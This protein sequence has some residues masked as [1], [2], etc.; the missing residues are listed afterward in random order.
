MQLIVLS[1]LEN[2]FT[3]PHDASDSL[4]RWAVSILSIILPDQ[5]L[6]AL[7][8]VPNDS[9]TGILPACCSCRLKFDCLVTVIEGLDS[10]KRRNY[11]SGQISVAT[12]HINNMHQTLWWRC[13]F[14]NLWYRAQWRGSSW[15]AGS[16]LQ[17]RLQD[18]FAKCTYWCMP[19]RL[20]HVCLC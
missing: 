5:R 11:N 16:G 14:Q 13:S 3:N 20:Q 1:D 7:A 2:D 10:Q 4:N 6:I 8:A 9:H 19:Q 17:A 15:F 18:A 12:R